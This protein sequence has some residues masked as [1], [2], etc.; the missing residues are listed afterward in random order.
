[1]EVLHFDAAMGIKVPNMGWRYVSISSEQH[2][3]L[4]GLNDSSRFYFVH[5]FRMAPRERSHCILESDYGGRF[6]AAVGVDNIF[7][8][9]F[10]PEKSHRFGMQLLQNFCDWKF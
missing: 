5:S 7:G 8:V 4:R 3:M 2:P 1:M 10:H 6:A 9:Q